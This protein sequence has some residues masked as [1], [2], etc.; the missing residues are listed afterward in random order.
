MT[1]GLLVGSLSLALSLVGAIW[2]IEHRPRQMTAFA[3]RFPAGLDPA[4]AVEFGGALSGLAHG[5]YVVFELV[6]RER[7]VEHRLLVPE[8]HSQPIMARLR[9]I[10]PSLRYEQIE[11]PALHATHA[12]GVRQKKFAA[13]QQDQVAESSRALLAGLGGLKRDEEVVV[14]WIVSGGF[15]PPP[16]PPRDAERE[17]RSEH[18]TGR[19]LKVRSPQV[20]AWGRIGIAAT[21]TNRHRQLAAHILSSYRSLR[22]AH[23]ALEFSVFFQAARTR[24]LLGRRRPLLTP[25]TLLSAPEL[26]SVIGWPVIGTDVAGLSTSGAPVLRAG[27]EVPHRGRV[28]GTSNFPSEHRSVAQPQLGAISHTLITG[29]TGVGKSALLSKLLAADLESRRSVVVVDGKGDLATGVLERMPDG[30]LRDLHILDLGFGDASSP[31]AG[32]RLFGRSSDAEL[33]ADLVLGVLADL[34]ADSWGPRSEQWLRVGLTTIASDPNA[35]LIDLLRL[36]WDDNYRRS[37]LSRIRSPFLKAS[38]AQFDAMSASERANVLAAPLNKLDAILGRSRLRAV[39]GQKHP[40]IDV[41]GIMNSGGTLVVNLATGAIGT[42]AARLVGALITYE[43]YRATAARSR[44]SVNQRWPS[45]VVIDEPRAL[46]GL[47]VPL[48]VLFEQARG[49]NVGLTI[50][51]QSLSQLPDGL[52]RAITSNVGTIGAFRQ[53]ADDATLLAKYFDRVSSDDLQGLEAFELLLRMGLGNGRVARPLTLS[54]EAPTKPVRR[55][56]SLTRDYAARVGQTADDVDA[57]VG[58][59]M[60]ASSSVPPAGE[61]FGRRRRSG[62]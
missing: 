45:M 43:V 57:A 28:F 5:N 51:T 46:V 52:G 2:W 41:G 16:E 14:Q 19:R 47:P 44:L 18:R 21:G 9:A 22:S 24:G 58:L 38:W 29:P 56:D 39:L 31:V 32:L 36:Y 6:A 17:A 20:A 7:S 42:L 62:S 61:D 15:A 40:A 33:A 26:A 54:T 11:L 34:F 53:N 23:G 60:D 30:R 13:L 49:H 1:E 27:D 4:A 55:A 25:H 12:I 10:V 59:R 8:S 35:T 37:L 50:A 3:L 48:D